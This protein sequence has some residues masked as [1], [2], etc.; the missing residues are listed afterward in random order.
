[1]MSPLDKQSGD[2]LDKKFLTNMVPHH[3][4]AVMM[5]TTLLNQN[6]SKHDET[7]TLARNIRDSQRTEIMK[8]SA[9]LQDWFQIDIMS[10]MM[11]STTGQST[12]GD[13]SGMAGHRSMSGMGNTATTR[14]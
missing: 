3:G 4:M 9:W 7:T 1:M 13:M 6:L 11:G 5:A 8:M 14:P 2:E 10:T 12:M